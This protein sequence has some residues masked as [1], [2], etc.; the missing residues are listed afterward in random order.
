[1]RRTSSP[2][3]RHVPQDEAKKRLDALKKERGREL[4]TSSSFSPRSFNPVQ[5]SS[6]SH[7]EFDDQASANW[8]KPPLFTSRFSKLGITES[9]GE[10]SPL[11]E[12][13][14]SAVTRVAKYVGKL[15]LGD[16]VCSTAILLNKD[17][18]LVPRHSIEGKLI[19][20]LHLDIA[21]NK[22]KCECVVEEDAELDY[23]VI[24]ITGG[25]AMRPV[26][27]ADEVLSDTILLHH[28]LGES[29]AVS[30][31]S[32]VQEN[33]EHARV[34]DV[35]GVSH[36]SASGSSGGAY[37]DSDGKIV[38]IH[39]GLDLY[40]DEFSMTANM[41]TG[42]AERYMM[43]IGSIVSKNPHSILMHLNESAQLG[44]NALFLNPIDRIVSWEREGLQSQSKFTQLLKTKGVD[45]NTHAAQQAAGVVITK[46]TKVVS[47]K[48]IKTVSDLKSLY[49][50]E[51]AQ[52]IQ[53]SLGKAGLHKD[54]NQHSIAG[55]IESD[56]PL[57]WDVW[58]TTSNTVL[59]DVVING[60]GSRP[61]EDNMP[62]IT[63][64][65]DKHRSLKTTGS[66]AACV[67]FRED[68]RTKCDAGNIKGALE[69]IIK[70]YKDN[71]LLGPAAIDPKYKASWI[72]VLE[73]YEH[74]NV[75]SAVER[76]NLAGML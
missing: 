55:E 67:Q 18:L 30:G 2:G 51:M 17:Y 70:N 72:D 32:R 37:I 49:P 22:I 21:G 47:F 43:P 10:I 11:T 5:A 53:T 26:Q 42:S 45:L 1:M 73:I 76:V 24:K 13:G 16:E 58:A 50:A 20:R 4:S 75:I 29:L 40:P 25:H 9:L 19:N 65:Y 41:G 33:M 46:R 15:C 60:K 64:P 57:P 68:L 6:A 39:L 27:F 61:G 23:A 59:N 54:T 8:D 12:S 66:S 28:P 38:A 74:M 48:D 44:I 7:S 62:A 52:T 3:T 63:I 14:K 31:H 71:E 35:V 36:D 69:D 56:H 34:D